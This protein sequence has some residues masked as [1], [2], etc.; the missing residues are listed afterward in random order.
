MGQRSPSL[1]PGRSGRAARR[2]ERSDPLARPLD[3]A[4]MT[5]R[6]EFGSNAVEPKF[7]QGFHAEHVEAICPLHPVPGERPLMLRE[8]GGH[9]GELKLDCSGGCLPSM[10]LAELRRLERWRIV[11]ALAERSP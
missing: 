2:P 7:S 9:G 11:R 6:L 5:L 3:R 1:G 4:V 8:R 10:I